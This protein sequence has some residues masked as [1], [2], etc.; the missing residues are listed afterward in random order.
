MLKKGIIISIFL[1]ANSL[2]YL[3][4][5]QT[6]SER[7]ATS[8]YAQ[9]GSLI[10]PDDPISKSSPGISWQESSIEKGYLPTLNYSPLEYNARPQNWA[11]VQDKRGIM[12]FGNNECILEFDGV[13]WRLIKTLEEST[14]RSLSIDDGGRIY[15]GALGEFGYLAPDSVGKL[16]YYSLLEFLDKKDLEFAD[17]WKTFV[18]QEGVFFQTSNKIFRWNG[19]TIKVWN[20]EEGKAFHLMFY[21]NEQIYVRQRDVGLMKLMDDKLVLIQ[22]GEVFAEKRIYFMLPF[23]NDAPDAKKQILLNTRSN[24]L[25][26]M[27]PTSADY[28]PADRF[29]PGQITK[30]VPFNT[31][32]DRFFI[33]TQIYNGI[34]LHNEN[35]SVGTLGG[36]L[37][38]IDKQGNLVQLLNKNTGLQDGTIYA[39]GKDNRDNLWLALANGISMVEINSPITFYN[40]KAGLEG[41]IQSITRHNGIL[42]VATLLGVYY[43]PGSIEKLKDQ[44][45]DVG[46]LDIYEPNFKPI[47]GISTECWDLLSFDDGIKSVL[48]VA[49]NIGIFEIDQ[50]Y[51]ANPDPIIV[52]DSWTLYTSK[53]DPSRVYIGV[54][55]GFTSIYHEG[56]SSRQSGGEWIDGGKIDDIEESISSVTED[57]DG[58]M[59]L[60]TRNQGVIKLNILSF[61][62]N[63]ID[64]AEIIRYNSSSGLPDGV[65]FVQHALNRTVFATAKGLYMFSATGASGGDNNKLFVPDT[66]LGKEFADSSWGIHR[67]AEDKNGNVWMVTFSDEKGIE[68]GFAAPRANAAALWESTPFLGISKEIIHAIY[69][70]D[71]GITWLGGP[72]GLFRYDAN[73]EKNYKQDFHSLIRKVILGEDS[74]IFWGAYFE[75]DGTITLNQPDHLKPILPYAHNSI[76]FEF[77]AQSYEGES[78]NRYRYFLEGFDKEW[79]DWKDETKT[80]YTNLP[81]GDY[82]FRVKAKN[83]YEHESIEA[84][85]TFTVLPPWYRTIWAYIGYVLSFISF[86]YGAI[87][88][89]TRGLQRIIKQKTA[90]VV[91]Q[92]EE[93][94][95]K[96]KDITDSINYA[97]KIQEAIL[98]SDKNLKAL[99]PDSFVL[100]KPKDIVS[101]DFYWL[102]EKDGKALIAAAD[103]TGHGVP[104]AFMSM[105]GSSLLNEIVNDK[106]ITQPAKVLDSLKEGII[107]S[108]QQTGKAGQQKDGMDIGFCTFSSP[109]KE[110][111]WGLMEFSGAY[112]PLFLIRN[113]ELE[114]TRADRMPIGIY[115]ETDKTFTNHEIPLQKGDAIYLFS[116]GFVDQFGGPKGKKFMSRRFKQL[117]L[118]IH[119]MDMI[120]QGKILEKTI[121]EWK[122][123]PDHTGVQFEQ[124]DDI[125]VIGIKI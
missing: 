11:V 18:T 55:N 30:I 111:K 74:I 20:A 83:T 115:E 67:M 104:G 60:G 24:G 77:A 52:C 14:V 100:F 12:Y 76:T 37:A 71:N 19:E 59:W 3:N 6:F 39:Q 26:T 119:K 1:V 102:T 4:E 28:F 84:V 72:G 105:I 45:Q 81:E 29:N 99:L 86:V 85:Y 66:I 113:N 120:E 42:Y 10:N 56:S 69:H 93:I 31:Q 65:V 53:L 41:T 43:L 114:E 2:L 116:D 63:K 118:D 123:H 124:M 98:P 15:V 82:Y 92:K 22:G 80:G 8:C 64:D 16:K 70:D 46:T 21:V 125:L 7:S 73:V 17:V 108:L 47:E 107:K 106:G 112:N 95:R 5:I 88:V 61:E 27:I 121:E 122:A 44:E 75:K 58:N 89:S 23:S 90:E 51:Q 68:I 110:G 32:I 91:K 38:V 40:D 101:G 103:C 9:S 33:E 48:L 94:E 96:N 13:K 36:G 62:N 50:N 87:T 49:T 57:K 79:T 34:K 78:A 117:F 35:Y 97:Q 25:Y 54:S 109:D